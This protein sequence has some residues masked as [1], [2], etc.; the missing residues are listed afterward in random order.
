METHKIIIVGAGVAGLSAGQALRRAGFDPLVLEARERI[1][2]RILTERTYGPVELG[3][4]FIHGEYAT[5]WE[6]VRAA[7]LATIPWGT[8]RYFARAGELFPA[9]AALGQ[10]VIA[11][12]SDVYAYTGPEISVAMWMQQHAPADDPAVPFALRWMANLEG[13]DPARLSA[14]AVAREHTESENGPTNFHLVHGYD[15]IPQTLAA[16]LTIRCAAP[17]Q[18][19]AWDLHG[20]TLTLLDGT[21]VRA[22]HV[23]VTVPLGV[24]QADQPQFVPALPEPKRSAIQA[25]AMGQVSKLALWF[26]RQCWPDFTVLSTDGQIATWWPVE[27]TDTPTLMGYTG[28]PAALA[29][30]ERGEAAVIALALEE[31][32]TL[33]GSAIRETLRG[34]RLMAWSAEPWSRGAY[35]YTPVGA[36]AARAQLAA[37]VGKV[38]FF[39]GEASVTNGHIGTVHGAIETGRRAAAEVI[40]AINPHHSL[41]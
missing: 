29:L 18:Q 32:S 22:D 41:I 2:G 38:L 10:Q 40:A 23:I 8:I 15:A 27:T 6:I 9:D 30:A 1:G 13:A 11:L 28:G 36:G 19:I 25:L 4:E 3:A 39:A 24:L 16:D 21:A 7:E 12:H 5:T 20:A 26:D 31:L 17:V 33:F 14:T 35:S 37:P 34:G